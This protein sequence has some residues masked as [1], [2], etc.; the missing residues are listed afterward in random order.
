MVLSDRVV[1]MN[2]GRIVQEGTP[3]AIYQRPSTRF[4]MEFLGQVDQ[5]G[6]R[7][8][9]AADGSPR[10]RL[11][12]AGDVEVALDAS[13]PWRPDDA[14]VLMLRSASVQ[15]RAPNGSNGWQGRVLSRIYLGERTEYVVGVG[16]ARVRA[17]GSTTQLLD[18]GALV[19]LEFPAEAI[20]AW[21]AERPA[22][23]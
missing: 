3:Q 19:Q 11:D 9:M 10:A 5:L 21:P 1:V 15:V 4:V 23:K 13:H 2:A 18:E 8:A 14:V 6:A 20:R 16:A 17:F 12:G 22:G 7:V